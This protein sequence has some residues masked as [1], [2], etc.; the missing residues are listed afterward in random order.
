MVKNVL[1]LILGFV[2]GGV[3]NFAIVGLGPLVIPVPEGVDMSDMENFAENLQKLKPVNFIAPWLAHAVG[4]L[5]GAMVAARIATSHRTLM[6]VIISVFF[7]AGG[8]TMVAMYGGP[9]W[10]TILDLVF[11]YIPMGLLAARLVGQPGKPGEP[12]QTA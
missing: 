1:G 2:I 3:V 8:I 11:A 7:L 6:A 10:F 5:V 9:V 4:T 12:A